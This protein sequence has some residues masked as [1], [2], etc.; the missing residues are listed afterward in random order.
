MGR[1]VTLF[2]GQ[3]ADLPL[4]T[5]CK[6]ARDFGYDGLELACWGDHFEVDKALADDAY[7]TRKRELLEK[8][9]LKLFAISNHLVGQA[10]L[11]NIDA[12]HKSILPEYVW[13]DGDP[14]GV[15]LLFD[16]AAQLEKVLQLFLGERGPFKGRAFLFRH[17]SGLSLNCV[18]SRREEWEQRCG[19]QKLAVHWWSGNSL[20]CPEPLWP[21]CDWLGSRSNE[22]LPQSSS[23]PNTARSQWRICWGSRPCS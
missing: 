11:D 21:P 9:D 1:P 16:R 19:G 2:T 20:Q 7:C 4:E 17:F 22:L 3:W 8:H 5:L 15:A 10:V 23:S 18:Y 12:R 6:K 14:A 13:G